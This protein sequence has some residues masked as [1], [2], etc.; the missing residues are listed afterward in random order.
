MLSTTYHR[1]VRTTLATTA[2]LAAMAPAAI[3]MPIDGG[4]STSTLPAPA[5]APEHVRVVRV[6]VDEGLDWSDAGIGAAGM[7]AVVLV[8][9]G[10]AHALTVAGRGR[11]AAHS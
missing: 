2:A 10:G 7:L 8:G 11:S 9:F 1:C 3:A 6:Q 4:G 5:P